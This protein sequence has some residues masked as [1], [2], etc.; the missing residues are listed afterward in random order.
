MEP[1]ETFPD[2]RDKPETKECRE[3]RARIQPF[4]VEAWSPDQVYPHLR[5]VT[6]A[7]FSN[8]AVLLLLRDDRGR[9]G[10][11]DSAVL[12]RAPSHRCQ[13]LVGVVDR[14]ILEALDVSQGVPFP[15]LRAQP[16]S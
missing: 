7:D 1:E 13:Q 11:Y 14:A 16:R 12:K 3:E 4:R 10:I 6:P 2:I 15:V 8:P 9:Y 5:S